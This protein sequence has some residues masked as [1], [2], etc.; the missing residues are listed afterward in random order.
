MDTELFKNPI[1]LGVCGGFVSLLFVYFDAKANNKE[2]TTASYVK[3]F[4]LVALLIGA[5]AYF[6]TDKNLQMIG[7]G[8]KIFDQINAVAGGGSGNSSVGTLDIDATDIDATD[9]VGGGSGIN[10][11]LKEITRRVLTN[12]PDW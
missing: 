11:D 4:G 1:V 9:M 3:V 10:E 12:A 5:V 6:M 2:T 8:S 7:G